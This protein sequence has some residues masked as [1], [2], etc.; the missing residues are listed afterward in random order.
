M[1]RSNILFRGHGNIISISP[2]ARIDNY[3]FKIY[4]NNNRIVIGENCQMK[5]GECLMEDDNNKIIIGAHT[6]IQPNTQLAS[7]EGCSII[8]GEDCMFSSDIVVRTG[9]SHSIVNSNNERVNKSED[10]HIGDHCWVGH[11]VMI[12]KGAFI[13]RNTIIGAGSIVNKQFEQ[14]NTVLAGIPAYKI[15]ENLNWLRERL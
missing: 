12:L 15:K 8:I 6:T 9:D 1:L 5:N 14:E 10:V 7:I 4:G 3:S 13:A 11:R 2:N